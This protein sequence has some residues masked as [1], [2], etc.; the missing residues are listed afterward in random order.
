MGSRGRAGVVRAREPSGWRWA[1][2]GCRVREGSPQ[3]RP[4]LPGEFFQPPKP[5]GTPVGEGTLG[6]VCLLRPC[7]FQARGNGSGGVG[8]SIP[9][10]LGQGWFF[11]RDEQGGRRSVPLSTLGTPGT[12]GQPSLALTVSPWSPPQPP[13]SPSHPLQRQ[14]LPAHGA[15]AA[16]G[17]CPSATDSPVSLCPLP[18]WLRDAARNVLHQPPFSTPGAVLG[19]SRTFGARLCREGKDRHFREL[20]PLFGVKRAEGRV[21][22]PAGRE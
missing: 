2:C 5:Q 22:T 14:A 10:S 3:V 7:R 17:H 19:F 8:G 1:V 9:R 12:P 11:N 4:L 16:P 15:H 6:Q 20:A 13:R 21:T 18:E